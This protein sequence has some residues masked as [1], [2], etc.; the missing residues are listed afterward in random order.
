MLPDDVAVAA[1]ERLTG[2]VDLMKCDWDGK[3]A[4]R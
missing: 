1:L 3:L 4:R 2:D